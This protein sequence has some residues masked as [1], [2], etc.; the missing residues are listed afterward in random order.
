[1]AAPLDPS[2]SALARAA[3]HPP[4]SLAPLVD[5]CTGVVSRGLQ[6]A[7]LSTISRPPLPQHLA[8]PLAGHGFDAFDEVAIALTL[9]PDLDP[10]LGV[11]ISEMTGNRASRYP[12]LSVIADL[13]GAREAERVGLAARLSPGGPLAAVGLVNLVPALDA[14]AAGSPQRGPSFLDTCVASTALLRWVFGITQLDPAL[15]PFVRDDLT[16]PARPPHSGT[17]ALLLP[18]LGSPTPSVTALIGP[19][20]GDAMATALYCAAKASRPALVVDAVALVDP[21]AAVRVAA[22]ALLREAVIIV[23]GSIAEVPRHHWATLST[24][25]TVGAEPALA[26][27]MGHDVATLVIATANAAA[28][29]RHLVDLLR[30]RGLT[31]TP[32]EA[33]RLTRW[34]H[35]HHED[36][37]QLADRLAARA[38]SGSRAVTA[39]DMAELTAG[40]GGDDLARLATPI[41]TS[42]DWSSLVLP[43]SVG[44]ELRELVDQAEQRVSLLE[45][46]G[47]AAVPGQPRGV[48]AVFAG[49]SGTGKT[50]AARLVAGELGLPLYAVNLAATVSKYIGE[51]ERNLDAVFAAAERSD[52]VLLFDEAEA[53]FGKR[54]EVHDAR[55]R[56]ANLE[57]A[58]LLQRMERYDGVAI[59]AT[60]LLGHFDDAFARRLAFCVRFP[61]PDDDQRLL[62]WRGVWPAGITLADDVDLVEVSRRH[63]FA[64]GHIRNVAVAAAHLA[65]SRG[66]LVDRSCIQRAI[67]REYAKLGQVPDALSRAFA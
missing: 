29:G 25:V 34:G 47:F 5:W 54:S 33:E 51:T 19:G 59:L 1:M 37:A 63:P 27:G 31:V 3:D 60:N 67:E 11:A 30:V 64:G 62:I 15:F 23:T 65:R 55:D 7:G 12:T 42:R 57:I 6:G 28:K 9:A 39:R 4:Q 45:E 24:V 32:A 14:R 26:P 35:L 58:F 46:S 41:A 36:L 56:Y 20:A 10:V 48:S 17:V 52:A 43:E 66:G 40:A 18:R 16:A 22:E 44:E 53:I 2:P 49:P 38:R 61:Y 21:A 13:V 50:L 8:R